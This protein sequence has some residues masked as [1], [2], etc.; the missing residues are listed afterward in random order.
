MIYGVDTNIILDVITDDTAFAEGSERT[1]A[2]AYDT[3]SLIICDLVY[4]EL[5][6]HFES[7]EALESLLIHLGIRI[8]ASSED[9]SWVAGRKWAE[10]R[11]AGGSRQRI[12][13]DFVIG[14]HA[15]LRADCL[16]TRDRGFFKTYFPELRLL[17][18]T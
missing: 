6:P 5:A 12:L 1:L 17:G 3:G 10:Y 13:P 8:V 11:L 16:I 9:V 4:A 2:D 14:A 15:V 18:Q 7:M